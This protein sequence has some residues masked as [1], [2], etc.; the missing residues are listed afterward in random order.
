ML[1]VVNNILS[2]SRSRRACVKEIDL[3]GQDAMAGVEGKRKDD[4]GALLQTELIHY[5][6]SLQLAEYLAEGRYFRMGESISLSILF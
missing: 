3:T 4:G 1:E 5:L 2:E 6:S